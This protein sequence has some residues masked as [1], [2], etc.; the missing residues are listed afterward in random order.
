MN[1]LYV[2]DLSIPLEMCEKAYDSVRNRDAF[3]AAVVHRFCHVADGGDDVRRER[4]TP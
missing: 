3:E 1:Q 2:D 4:N